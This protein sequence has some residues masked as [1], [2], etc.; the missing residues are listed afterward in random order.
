MR[1]MTETNMREMNGGAIGMY[2][3]NKCSYYSGNNAIISLHCF[4]YHGRWKC[5]GYV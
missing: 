1:A 4:A 3:C 2:K 5:W